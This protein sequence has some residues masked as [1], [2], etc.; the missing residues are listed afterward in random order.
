MRYIN[1]LYI[2]LTYIIGTQQIINLFG[3]T[4]SKKTFINN[5]IIYQ[6]YLLLLENKKIRP[7]PRAVFVSCVV[8]VSDPVII[9]THKNYLKK[10]FSSTSKGIAPRLPLD[11]SIPKLRSVKN[12]PSK[13]ST[14]KYQLQ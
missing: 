7:L 11:S 4:D 13:I 5:N 2:T 9:Y 8:I 1:S 10:H 6:H 12:F 3:M 14:H